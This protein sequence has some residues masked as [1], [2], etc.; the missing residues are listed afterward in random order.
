MDESRIEVDRLRLIIEQFQRAQFGGRS[1][2]LDAD[3][4]LVQ[5]LAHGKRSSRR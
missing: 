5:A 4:H 3:S 2:K 1:E